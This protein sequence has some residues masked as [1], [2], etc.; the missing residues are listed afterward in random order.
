MAHSN[1]VISRVGGGSFKKMWG[2]YRETNH[3]GNLGQSRLSG[4]GKLTGKWPSFKGFRKVGRS[5][6]E[7]ARR[8]CLDFILHY[9]PGVPTNQHN[10]ELFDKLH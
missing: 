3:M 6:S 4:K 8:N 9:L 10:R 5:S 2:G 1:W 7:G